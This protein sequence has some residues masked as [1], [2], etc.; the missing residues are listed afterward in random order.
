MKKIGY[1]A[2]VFCFLLGNA[3]HAAPQSPKG[4]RSTETPQPDILFILLD[5]L[6][7]DALS[8]KGHPYVKTPNID[9][10]REGGA[11]LENAFCSTSI[12]CPSRATFMTGTYANRH[13]VID[14]ATSEY[15]PAV[16]PPLTK[17]LQVA[18]YKTAMIGKWH[19]G[20]SAEP[21]PYFDHWISFEGQGEYN[22][23]EVN[24]DG[25]KEQWT[26]YTTDILTDKAIEFIKKQPQDQ[27]YFC[28]LS[29][30]AV[31][32]PF[33]PAPR[34]KHA[35]G[36]GTRD[37]EPESWSH[38][39]KGKPAWLRR[40]RIRDTRWNYRTRDVEEDQLPD[41]IPSEPWVVRNYY[42]K[43]LRCVAAVDDGVG[44]VLKALH[45]RGTLDNTLI[46]FTSDNGYLHMEHRRWDKRLAVE[47]SMRIPMIA[48]YPGHI[49]KNTT[50][51]E[52]VSNLDFAPTVLDYAGVDIP[53]FM[54]GKSMRPLFEGESADWRDSVFYEYWVDLVHSIPTMTA[55]RTERYKLIEYPEINDLDEL[56]DLKADPNEMNNLAVNPEYAELHQE[57]K[58]RM[59]EKKAEA[60]WRPD[61]FPKNLPRCRGAKDL[62]L[63]IIKNT[64]TFSGTEKDLVKI[65][66]N[67]EAD[68][69]S[70]PW[71]IDMDVKPESDGVIASQSSPAY[72]F[73]IF[74]QD[75][76][77]GI[78]VLCKTWIALR[79]VIDTPESVIGKWTNIQAS[80][81]YN[82]VIF[83]VDGKLIESC[84]LPQPF[85]GRTGQPLIIG[86][87]G[88]N[89]VSEDVPHNP[90][91]GEIKGLTIQRGS[92]K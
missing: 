32:E 80:I 78:A 61:V 55:V 59:A 20:H 9:K 12:C 40:Q 71:R 74:V 5:D 47:E 16:T 30:K 84:P 33:K 8:Y 1:I 69:S 44:R 31:H 91:Q 34:H 52:L 57:M 73:K 60:G 37:L 75:G 21:R 19:M 70:W 56:Y 24:V 53:G 3:V 79:T 81:D 50:I 83:K 58:K 89:K 63:E 92:L 10:L 28:M 45:E 51:T 48:A 77:P 38:D 49:M 68:P 86:G 87:A 62:K 46:I 23:V 14:N 39:L 88:K 65:P 72:G 42:T 90:F 54:Q 41:A 29:H 17:Y 13:G 26:G 67:E 66:Y 15:N 7:W 4:N 43:Q 27:P 11:S 25:K 35:F 6:R 22:D 18:G 82:R 2:I 36:A 64:A 76:R 85:K